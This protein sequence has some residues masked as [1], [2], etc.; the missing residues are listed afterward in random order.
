M[1]E[2][3]TQLPSAA[4]SSLSDIICAVQGYVS[5]SVPGTS[6]QQTL[7]QVLTLFQQN[8]PT[9]AWV[10]VTS[11]TQTMSSNKGYVIDNG[12]SLVTLTLPSTSAIGDQINIVG[13]SSGGWK[14]VYTSGQSVIIGSATSTVT[15][16]NVASTNAHDAITLICTQAN[17][18]W[19]ALSLISAGITIV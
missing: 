4:Y 1:N 17:G 9:I 16:G 8:T 10:H 5:P 18:E 7:S 15:T 6:T 13:R 19:T 3:F 12:A 2:M 11:N 14:V